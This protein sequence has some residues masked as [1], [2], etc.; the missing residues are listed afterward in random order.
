MNIED[1]DNEKNKGGDDTKGIDES[2]DE[3]GVEK[4]KGSSF[5]TTFSEGEVADPFQF[6]NSEIML[7]NLIPKLRLSIPK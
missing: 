1:H 6:W 3:D 5:N 4:S 2:E 7:K